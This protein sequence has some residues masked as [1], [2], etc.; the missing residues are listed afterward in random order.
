[1]KET[2]FCKEAYNFKEPTTCSEPI[3]DSCLYRQLGA[4]T[5]YTLVYYMDSLVQ[6]VF[7]AC[8]M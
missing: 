7:R 1:M 5:L 6:E 2:I 8:Y 3:F 4:Y